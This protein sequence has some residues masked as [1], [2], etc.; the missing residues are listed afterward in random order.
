MFLD[1]IHRL[2]L[3]FKT[4]RFGDW[5]LSPSPVSE[6]FFEI[7]EQDGVLDKE[8]TMDNVQKHN[9]CTNAPSSQ[10]FRSYLVS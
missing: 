6:T 7:Y 2:F 8:R 4:R 5:I 3:Y 1:T 9:I 10:T